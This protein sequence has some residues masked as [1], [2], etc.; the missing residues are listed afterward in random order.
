MDIS[1]SRAS[2]ER[3]SRA[4]IEKQRRSLCFLVL[5]LAVASEGLGLGCLWLPAALLLAVDRPLD[6]M[7]TVV[8]VWSDSCAAAV[9]ARSEGE[10]G[11]LAPATA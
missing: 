2:N 10:E 8:N 3:Q 5:F 1:D 9:V 7:R 6:M 4:S 11:P